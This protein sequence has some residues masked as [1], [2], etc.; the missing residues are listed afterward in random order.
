MHPERMS[1][2]SRLVAK[3]RDHGIAIT[4]WTFHRTH[5]GRAQRQAEAWSW[6]IEWTDINDRRWEIGSCYPVTQLLRSNFVVSRNRH[7]IFSYV[8]E[9]S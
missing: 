1:A 6:W 7:E 5:A 8:I 3:I 4:T 9:L 2:P